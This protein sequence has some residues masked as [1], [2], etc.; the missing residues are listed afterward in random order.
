[1]GAAGTVLTSGGAAV[2]PTFT[3]PPGGTP[4]KEKWF[5][6]N[7]D[8]VIGNYRVKSLI[9][10][11]ADRI[12]FMIPHD[13]T[14]LTELVL[15]GITSA[16][17]AGAGK[18]IDLYSDYAGAGEDAQT[19]QESDTTS[20]YTIPAAN[21]MWEFDISGVFSSLSAGDYCGV[22]IDHK[23]IGGTIYYLGIRLKYS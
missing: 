1:L 10:S 13:F 21:T 15:V 22:Q 17:A 4:T 12:T 18:D 3:A 11:G 23:S 6:P 14:S 20:T 9:G 7:H 8:G 19:H 16:G 5:A 2:A